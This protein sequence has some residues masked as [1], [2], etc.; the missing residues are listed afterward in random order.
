[1]LLSRM[2][3]VVLRALNDF[4]CID[5]IRLMAGKSAKKDNSPGYNGV[6]RLRT[7]I[8]KTEMIPMM[9]E[10]GAFLLI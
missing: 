3:F 4:Y 6:F 8:N 7:M 1:M 2:F 10:R 9:G 5:R